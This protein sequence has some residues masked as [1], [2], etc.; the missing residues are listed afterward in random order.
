MGS[1]ATKP[2]GHSDFSYMYLLQI[3]CSELDMIKNLPWFAFIFLNDLEKFLGFLY[4]FLFVI[5]VR[6]TLST[7]V[8]FLLTAYFI[9]CDTKLLN[10]NL[11]E[12]FFS[13]FV[14][15]MYLRSFQYQNYILLYF[16]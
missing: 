15:Y 6:N 3:S 10:C 8:V 11:V 14:S 1:Q 5:L 16:L 4:Q 12:L 9:C 13:C 2:P 7:F